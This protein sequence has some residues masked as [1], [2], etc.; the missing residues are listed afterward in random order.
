VFGFY[1]EFLVLSFDPILAATLRLPAKLL[2][3]F[4]MIL[5]A[6]AI[7]VSLQT[8]GVALMV[9]MLVTPAATAYLISPRLPRMIFVAAFIA[10][11]SG[12]IG[13][14]LSY[15]FSLASGGVIV[16]TTTLIFL[17]VWAW[18]NVRWRKA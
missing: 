17:I 14:Y 5:I 1:K 12:L 9:A 10:S 6:L 2:D 3:F 16:L 13:L 7:V 4:L 8:V 15:Y 18:R 11:L